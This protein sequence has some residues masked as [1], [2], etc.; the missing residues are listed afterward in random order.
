MLRQYNADIRLT[1]KGYEIG[2]INE[3]RYQHTLDKINQIEAEINRLEKTVVGANKEVQDLLQQCGST[4]LG[5]ATTLAELIRRPELSYELLQPID[6]KR[7][8]LSEEVIEQVNI[9]IKY[10]GYIR[11]QLH[12]IEQFKKLENRMIPET[13]DYMAVPSLRIEARQKL[14]KFM[15]RSIGQASRISGVSPADISVLLVYLTQL[16]YQNKKEKELEQ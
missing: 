4:R 13:I 12:Q 15:P 11:R 6:H 7:N 8:E 14:I 1:K 5:T 16:N 10:D 3:G 2:L 9:N